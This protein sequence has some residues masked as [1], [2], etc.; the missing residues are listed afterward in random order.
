M[1]LVKKQLSSRIR[2]ARPQMFTLDDLKEFSEIFHC[3]ISNAERRLRE[4][5][6]D[7][8]SGITT[9]RDNHGVIIGWIY[10]PIVRP[11]EKQEVNIPVASYSTQPMF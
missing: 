8:V 6:R 11:V 7:Q 4:L 1:L 3:K 10:N 2:A 5:C 9:C